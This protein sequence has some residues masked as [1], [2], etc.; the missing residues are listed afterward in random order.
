MGENPN[1]SAAHQT[2]PEDRVT[3]ASSFP[4]ACCG[5]PV[6]GTVRPKAG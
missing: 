2:G 1:P 5:F 6:Y 3:S 4:Q